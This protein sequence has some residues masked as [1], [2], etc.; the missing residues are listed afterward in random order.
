MK[1]KK[2]YTLVELLIAMSIIS[3]ISMLFIGSI[4]TYK[5]YNN[6]VLV[7]YCNSSIVMF[8]NDAKQFSKAHNCTSYIMFSMSKQSIELKR[9]GVKPELELIKKFYLPKGFKFNSIKLKSSNRFI[10][11]DHDG[12]TSD[13]GT[14]SYEDMEKDIKKISIC[15]GSF[16]VDIKEE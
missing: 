14:I 8:I 1:T 7:D 5:K 2:G 15:V 16:S 13:A 6:K 3:I 10:M 9:K 11:V 12:N 4:E